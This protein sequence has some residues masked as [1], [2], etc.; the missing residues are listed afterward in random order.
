MP[1]VF[2]GGQLPM[3]HDSASLM[4]RGNIRPI[5]RTASLRVPGRNVE[6][7]DLSPYRESRLVAIAPTGL[8]E[9]ASVQ[10]QINPSPLVLVAAL[11]CVF[12]S[13]WLH[14]AFF[15]VTRGEDGFGAAWAKRAW[16]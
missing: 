16:G 14:G 5:L 6:I 2:F 8:A 1:V 7:I 4:V 9:A 10:G 3:A 15:M 13:T 11:A 12:W